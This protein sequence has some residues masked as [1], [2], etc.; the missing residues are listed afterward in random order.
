VKDPDLNIDWGIENPMLSPK[1]EIAQS[2]KSLESPFDYV[3]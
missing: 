2:F 1:D 3:G